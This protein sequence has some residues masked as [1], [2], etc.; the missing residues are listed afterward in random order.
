MPFQE[1]QQLFGSHKQPNTI[2][3]YPDKEREFTLQLTSTYDLILSIVMPI[4]V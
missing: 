4:H 2:S 1:T 3:F